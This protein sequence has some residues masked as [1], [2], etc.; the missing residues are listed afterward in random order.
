MT[1]FEGTSSVSEGGAN[2]EWT[3]QLNT[4]PGVEVVVTITSD[5]TSRATATPGVITFTAGL[6]GNDRWNQPVTVRVTSEADDDIVNDDV[7]FK[8]SVTSGAY[9]AE[10]AEV[11]VTVDDNADA[12][13][14]TGGLTAVP[15]T[16][17]DDPS[18]ELSGIDYTLTVPEGGTVSY[19]MNLSAQ[20]TATTVVNFPLDS[21]LISLNRERI[22][23]RRG[24]WHRARAT[25]ITAG[26][27]EN[28]ADET[29]VITH[30]ATAGGGY[31]GQMV[32][33]QVTIDDTDKSGLQLSSTGITVAEGGDG[34]F[35]VRLNT[36]PDQD[37]TVTPSVTPTNDEVTF[38][39]ETLTFTDET[40]EETQT[41][42]VS[43]DEDDDA[44]DDTTGILLTVSGSATGYGADQNRTV[45]VTVDDNDSA[46]M[47][48]SETAVTIT[49]GATLAQ[50]FS[51][52]L[53]AAPVGS[54][55][56]NVTS[57]DTD[58]INE[59]SNLTF[60][61]DDWSVPKFVSLQA[62]DELDAANTAD[63]SATITIE[64]EATDAADT[65][66]N[67]LMTA[68]VRVTIEDDDKPGI[69]VSRPTQTVFEGTD[70]VSEGSNTEA[71]WT[72]SLNEA[73]GTGE[74]VVVTITTSDPGAAT[75]EPSVI[76][77]TAGQSGPTT[78]KV[79]GVADNDI[80]NETVTFTHTSD[81]SGYGGVSA[82]VVVTVTDDADATIV[83][84]LTALTGASQEQTAAGV[85]HTITVPEG[86]TASFTM[87]LSARPSAT[88]V[89][90]F[91]EDSDSISV[92][93]ERIT[94]RGGDWHRPRTSE[95]TAG[96]DANTVDET[97]IITFTASAGGG[98][99]GEMIVL[100]VT[101]DD[102]GKSGLQ[103]NRTGLTIG[104]GGSGTFT[105]R[106]NTEPDATVTVTPSE[107]T[108]LDDVSFSPATLT[109]TDETWEETQTITVSTEEDDDAVDDTTGIELAVSGATGYAAEQNR[110]VSVTVDDNDSAGMTV[111]ETAVTIT[112]GAT[113][114]QAFSVVLKAAP[115]GSVTVNVTSSDTD[116]INEPSNLTF[117]SD[118]WSVPKFVSLQADDELDAANTADDSATITIETEATDAADTGFNDLMTATVRVT[119]E[120]DD[121]PGIQVSRPTQTVFEGTDVVSEGSNTEAEWTV[122][123]NEAPGTG[124]TVV[125]TITTSDPG[126]ATVEPSVIT[127][128]A[129]QSGPTT[130]KV[131]GVAD[132]DIENE[133]VTFT[134]TSDASGY[135]GVSAQVVVTVTDDADATIV[136]DL[137]ALTGASQEQTAAGV[138][139]TITV[140]EGGT[141]SFTMNLSARPSATTVVS[142]S[143]D[144][145]SI[146]VS[147]ERITFR[148]GDWHRART[149]EI[150]AG[151]DANTVDET[152]IITF[153]AS[154][155]GGYD[156]EMIVLEVTVDD[157]G[158]SGLQLNRTGLTIGEG[159]SGTFTV[160]LNT[161]P[162][163]TVT[164]TPSES[165]DLDDVSF[166]P[167]TL[168]FTDET[169]EETQTITVSTEEDDD[170]VDDTTG[171]ELAVSGATG[172]A[173]EQNRTVSVTVD[174]NDSAGM[175][176]SETAVT[177]TEGATLAQA[178]S[179]V[180]KAA[181]VG[182]VTVNVTS[183]DTDKINEPSNLTFS[184]DDWSVP[185]FV[186]LQADDELDAANTADDS[187]TITIETE[188][189][190]AAD[191]GFN[192]LMTAT[193]RVTIEDDDKPGI[194]VSRPTQTV[195]E[196][197]DVVSEG[198][199]TEAEWT[200]SLNEAPGTGETV[201]VTITTS[202]P[203]AA[204]VEPS[205]ITYTA[206]QSGPTTVKVRG[207]ADNDIENETV[208]FTHTSDASG[209]GGVSAQVVVTVTDD[210]DATIVVGGLTEVPEN[211]RT[212][213]LE[214]V[215]HT[216]TVPEGGTV[217][218]TMNLSARAV[219][220]D[221]GVVR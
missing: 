155:G 10:D 14:V 170:A 100:E 156:G 200:V 49:E 118:D 122:S 140:P 216:I 182:S 145:D 214:G 53:K 23:F 35:T 188:A 153:T 7:R 3:V 56:V 116:K 147:R 105:V 142:F 193:V 102:S 6:S 128:T 84:D 44:V 197:T 34:T 112:E 31:G 39:P 151:T 162:D 64:T 57:S 133:T 41:V 135:G 65:G 192:D 185:K 77:Y 40:W 45:S 163:A 2:A 114:A 121:K 27:D 13:I 87:N 69:Q 204:T 15:E 43:T 79:R 62:D 101:V 129:G 42:T 212:G 194:Q 208:T 177:I 104:E 26:T 141:A 136:T 201:V 68:T 196:G 167:A 98:Y 88:T 171:I 164:V 178:F 106:L 166:S 219:G 22:T 154:A 134:H 220:D 11:V 20:P 63:D 146:S 117:S 17:R 92:S 150:T 159:G 213:D 207:V 210:A 195:F 152:A 186:S 137:T 24:D 9:A 119:I 168:T 29:V 211:D 107:S 19:M 36:E 75:V 83:T 108:D 120:D 74:T 32:V 28:S 190:D 123:L 78:V 173:A 138:T 80:E 191:T 113:L 96:T 58:K 54:V 55:T 73:P 144:S 21:E 48:V 217:S 139:H 82:Q 115:V 215:T 126:A 37:V 71:E 158:K 66:F 218:Y 89:V 109:F 143:E 60:S 1:V 47:T 18:H 187:A 110:T 16:D 111:S 86:G 12:R 25:E 205:V 97:A 85:T 221:G 61:S 172:Y 199:N 46:G 127:Y 67:D 72:V 90:S 99:D 203:G 91:S 8:H 161:E 149:S 209:Y 174:D 179:V 30:T 183:S 165:T 206:G 51:V 94:F 38:L 76:T 148:G 130:V 181:P 4:D 125:V 157:S 52:V 5:D 103:L 70:V 93:R 180:L 175:T 202:D 176:V 50:A 95:I 132:N 33:L 184:S 124:E 160:R 169:W 59:P 81:A 198:S 131:R 189:T